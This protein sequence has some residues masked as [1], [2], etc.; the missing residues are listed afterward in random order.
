VGT[1]LAGIVYILDVRW[2]GR[3]AAW[4]MDLLAEDEAPLKR[5]I[6]LVLGVPHGWRTLNPAFP[7]GVFIVSDATNEGRDAGFDDMGDRVLVYFYTNE[8]F[9][10]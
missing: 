1:T 7:A 9:T 2:N 10:A 4:Y 5:G 6:K 8:E 3:D